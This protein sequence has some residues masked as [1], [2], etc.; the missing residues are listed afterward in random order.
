MKKIIIFILVISAFHSCISE[1][2]R[3]PVFIDYT[4]KNASSHLVSLSFFNVYINDGRYVDTTFKI[5]PSSEIAYHPPFG[6]TKDSA[7]IIF[8]NIKQIIYRRDDGKLSNIFIIKNY[9]GG[10]VTEYHYL[11]Q[12]F[13]TDQ[14]YANATPLK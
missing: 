8:D 14:D 11:Y 6:S 4:I 3:E 7:Y 5:L 1:P 13:I 9:I 2:E 12:Y 10:K